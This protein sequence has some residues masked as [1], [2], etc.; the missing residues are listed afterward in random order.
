[1]EKFDDIVLSYELQLT[2]FKNEIEFSKR[3]YDEEWKYEK[4]SEREYYHDDFGFSKGM[5][6]WHGII[7]LCRSEVWLRILQININY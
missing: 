3:L 1:M 5:I 2:Q 6:F 7:F 4:V